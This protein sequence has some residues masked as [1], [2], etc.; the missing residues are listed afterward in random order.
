M[1]ADRLQYFDNA[2]IGIINESVSM[3]EE[4]VSNA[5]KMSSGQWRSLKYDIK[6]LAELSPDEIA[7]GP[8]AQVIR[9]AAKPK[10][11]ALGSAAYNFYKICLQ[12]HSI[13]PLLN[14]SPEIRLFPFGLYIVTHELIHIVRFCK[15]LQHFDASP[16]EKLAE[17]K[18]IFDK[19]YDILSSVRLDGL[20]IVFEKIL[21]PS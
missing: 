13:L 7:F 6:T 8:Y 14:R 3:A 19:T 15:F 12:D 17:E 18:R 10:D 16:E 11:A 2:Q 5:Y 20:E 4:L 1:A 9:Y 21:P